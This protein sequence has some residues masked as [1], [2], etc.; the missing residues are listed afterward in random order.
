M[1][2]ARHQEQAERAG[3]RLQWLHALA[4]VGVVFAVDAIATLLWRWVFGADTPLPRGFHAVNLGVP[5]A[6]IVGGAWIETARLRE[7]G[8][9]VARRLGAVAADPM[10]EL[11]RIAQLRFPEPWAVPVRRASA[12]RAGWV[13]G[14]R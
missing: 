8:A 6:L 4:S 12:L 10:R 5:A 13:S 7:D 9:I 14:A 2:F 1:N 11:G 3:R